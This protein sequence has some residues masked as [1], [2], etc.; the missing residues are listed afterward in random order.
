MRLKKVCEELRHPSLNNC[1]HKTF[2]L[3]VYPC[4]LKNLVP[5]SEDVPPA[6]FQPIRKF[7]RDKCVFSGRCEHRRCA[8]IKFEKP[9]ISTE[10]FP[11]KRHAFVRNMVIFWGFFSLSLNRSGK[12]RE[13]KNLVNHQRPRHEVPLRYFFVVHASP[14]EKF[15]SDLGLNKL[16]NKNKKPSARVTK[17][18]R[19]WWLTRFFFSR[20]I[21][22]VKRAAGEILW[23]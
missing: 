8:S 22:T 11:S 3:I 4:G 21:Y 6:D 1:Y 17:F 7:L 19:H 2:H 15:A 5:T 9:P 12:A 20:L 16:E 13:K 18:Q 10:V 14:D 23:R